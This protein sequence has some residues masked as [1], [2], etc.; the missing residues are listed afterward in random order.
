[1]SWI[2]KNAFIR[3]LRRHLGPFRLETYTIGVARECYPRHPG[4]I[5][6]D[7]QE[8]AE[9]G[10]TVITIRL[11]GYWRGKR[12]AMAVAAF[13]PR[14]EDMGSDELPPEPAE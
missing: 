9:T 7:G 6:L 8:W 11:F 13:A 3:T 2:R 1:M 10:R 4:D 14:S 5:R 12:K